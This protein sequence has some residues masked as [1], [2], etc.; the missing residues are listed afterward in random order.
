VSAR[1][2]SFNAAAPIENSAVGQFRNTFD[3]NVLG[4]FLGIRAVAPVMRAAGGGAIVLVSSAGGREGTPG[5]ALYATSK[6]ANAYFAQSAAL[7]LVPTGIRVNAVAPGLVDTEMS[8]PVLPSSAFDR[9]FVSGVP[10]W[11]Q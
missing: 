2:E 5:T 7:E 9:A 3:V 1:N 11:P 6:A 10:R 4:R 8:R